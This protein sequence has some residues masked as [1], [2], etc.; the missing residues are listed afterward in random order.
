MGGAFAAASGPHPYGVNTRRLEQ[1]HA[2]FSI[3]EAHRLVHDGRKALCLPML[4]TSNGRELSHLCTKLL[5]L[6]DSWPQISVRNI[7]PVHNRKHRSTY[8][9]SPLNRY[10]DL[11]I[12]SA[13]SSWWLSNSPVFGTTTNGIPYLRASRIEPEP[14]CDIARPFDCWTNLS[15]ASS[16]S[17][18]KSMPSMTNLSCT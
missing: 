3:H 5:G 15:C 10:P 13:S 11:S 8:S 16:P 2:D 12:A 18:L 4:S 1:L 14:A 9:T 17:G 7:S 6:A